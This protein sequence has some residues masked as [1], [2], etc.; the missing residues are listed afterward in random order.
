MTP[1]CWFVPFVNRPVWPITCRHVYFLTPRVDNHHIWGYY[2]V[3]NPLFFGSSSLSALT[4]RLCKR[5]LLC[6]PV[7]RLI[8]EAC[9]FGELLHTPHQSLCLCLLVYLPLL[10]SVLS[11]SPKET[12]GSSPHGGFYYKLSLRL[13]WCCQKWTS[14]KKKNPFSDAY[15]Y[16]VSIFIVSVFFNIFHYQYH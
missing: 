15:F 12:Q 3:A 1:N 13:Q 16:S 4:F 11:H 2:Y 14:L 8:I 10:F 7:S 5:S 9:V 6:A